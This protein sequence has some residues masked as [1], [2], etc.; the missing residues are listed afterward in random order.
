MK[1]VSLSLLL[2]AGNLFGQLTGQLSGTVT[3]ATGAAIPGA[4]VSVFLPGGKTALLT[5]T[6]SSDG[7][8]EFIAVRPDLY[9]VT[10]ES[11][12]FSKYSIADVKVDPARRLTLPVIKLSIASSA[13]TVEVVATNQGVDVATAEV[14]TTV[15]QAQI[16]NLPV[17]G[18][19][20]TNL[21]V[22]QAGV[23]S[24]L[25]QNTV[26]NGMRPSFSNVLMDGVNV[27]DSV[28]INDLDFLP[29]RFTI[30]QVAEFTVST[31]NS[32]PTI[33]G[34]ASTI[35][36]VTP[37]GTNE[38]HGSVY[39]FNRNKYFSSNDWFSNRNGQ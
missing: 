18:R 28:R 35:T 33:G 14:A 2:A 5:A 38:T 15:S 17:I 19:Q 11:Q 13:Q 37:S 12:G 22:T 7:I 26:I 23:T 29:Q 4:T 1:L 21:F 32:S 16:T 34:A 10:V 39:W 25:R 31:T 9:M 30:A 20:I 24:N 36:M 27:Q 8:F 6:T 3:D